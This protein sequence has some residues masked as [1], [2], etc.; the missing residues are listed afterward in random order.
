M[1]A[2]ICLSFALPADL[3]NSAHVSLCCCDPTQ[4][5]GAGIEFQPEGYHGK[6]DKLRLNPAWR[7]SCAA[8]GI[9]NFGDS[10]YF[11]NGI[12]GGVIL[13]HTKHARESTLFTFFL[14]SKSMLTAL[15]NAVWHSHQV[16]RSF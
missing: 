15:E 8:C 2:F 11:W 6:W 1:L 16:T 7:A 9:G 13:Y 4:I 3:P 14:S 5:I 12:N 10:P